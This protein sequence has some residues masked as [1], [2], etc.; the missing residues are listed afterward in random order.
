MKHVFSTS[1]IVS[2][3]VIFTD[4]QTFQYSR[5]WTNGKRSSPEQTAPSRT[6]LPHIPL[7]IDKPDEE[8]RLLIQRF[9]KSPCDVRLANAI[10]S[11]N[12]DLLRD[13]ADDVNDGTALLYDP[14]PMVDTTAGEDVRF[15]RGTID[16]HL[17]GDDMRRF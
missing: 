15:K 13:M 17:L 2:L 16:R 3:F 7:G 12:K 1:L 11:R 9:L 10:V 5:G 8:C 4:A 14:V 6:L